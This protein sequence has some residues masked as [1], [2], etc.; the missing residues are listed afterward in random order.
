MKVL[1]FPGGLDPDEFIRQEGLEAFEAL[2]P[3][4]GVYYRMLREKEKHDMSAE[5]GRTEYAKACAGFLP[6]GQ[7]ARG[8]GKLCPA[9]G[10]GD[11]L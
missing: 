11:R 9:A 4:S 5:E 8:A 6:Q 10:H 2:K 3:I 1:D 7:G